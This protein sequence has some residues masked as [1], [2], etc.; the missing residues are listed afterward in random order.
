MYDHRIGQVAFNLIEEKFVRV[1]EV[2]THNIMGIDMECLICM[3]MPESH[4]DGLAY[5]QHMDKYS[6]LSDE[7]CFLPPPFAVGMDVYIS[8][9]TS[10]TGPDLKRMPP[11]PCVEKY[12]P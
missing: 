7:L 4:D 10:L 5:T 11:I 2:E 6:Y 8:D 1:I 3:D 9:G 12:K